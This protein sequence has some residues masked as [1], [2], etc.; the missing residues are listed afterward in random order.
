MGSLGHFAL[1]QTTEAAVPP[2]RVVQPAWSPPVPVLGAPLAAVMPS[3]PARE[4]GA[5]ERSA[6][7]ES[8]SPWA[9]RPSE[10]PGPPTGM[11]ESRMWKPSAASDAQARAVRIAE[12]SHA[13]VA[14]VAAASDAA[15]AA[16]PAPSEHAAASSAAAASPAA[17]SSAAAATRTAPRAYIDLLWFDKDAPRHIRA[18]TS[19]LEALREPARDGDWMTADEAFE[20]K[21]EANDRRDVIRA[22]S[23]V[24]AV[25]GEGVMAQMTAAIDDDG[26]L[27]RPLVVV[28]G[29]LQLF[30]E[31][32][33]TLKATIAVVSPLVGAD[34]KLKEIADAAN[35]TASS[36]WRC[37]SAVA[38]GM[39]TRLKEAFAQTTRGLPSNYVDSSVERILLEQRRYQKRTILGSARLRAAL[40]PVGTSPG[41]ASAIPA[42]LPEHLEKELPMFQRFQVVIVAEAHSQQDQFE[43]HAA[44]LVVLALGR[45]LPVQG[46]GPKPR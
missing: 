37:T 12:V 7:R 8:A 31:E 34:K 20:A 11:G 30:F 16:F 25:D 15:A 1:S 38:E 3:T 33:E 40:V 35:E 13:A 14:S 27:T 4:L 45:V 22:L 17:A 44:A 21:Q 32:M 10:A 41:P 19:W 26:V 46:R 6:P 36:E 24:P 9:S 42:Y 29:E 5:N 39:T 2:A 23:R 28:K 43:N 18:Q